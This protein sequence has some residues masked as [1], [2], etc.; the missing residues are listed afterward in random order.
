MCGGTQTDAKA[1]PLASGLSPRVRGNLTVVPPRMA[2]MRTIP[3]CAGEPAAVGRD[4]AASGDYPRVCGGTRDYVTGIPGWP[5]LSPRVRG[6]LA[7]SPATFP[8]GGTIPACAGEPISGPPGA[9]ERRDYPRVCGGTSN[10][11]APAPAGIGLSPRVRG[12]LPARNSPARNS[13]TIPACAGEPA[14]TAIRTKRIRDYP[15]V[16]GGTLSM[17]G[18]LGPLPGLS[19]RVRGNRR[20][21]IVSKPG[22]RTIP[23]CAGEPQP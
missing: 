20:I 21:D 17:K 12:N 22:H 14:A 15:R 11:M 1:N 19:P 8:A 23:A 16:C 10:T 3:A 9:P 4:G 6:N 13:R 18:W 5:G 2:M 7:V